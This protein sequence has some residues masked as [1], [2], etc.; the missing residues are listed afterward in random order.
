MLRQGIGRC[1]QPF[2]YVAVLED[3]AVE[4]L[5][6]LFPGKD[7]RRQAEIFYRVA[8]FH[9]RYFVI[10]DIVLVG[11]NDLPYQPLPLGPEAVP[12]AEC[13]DGQ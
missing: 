7:L 5:L 1:L 10:E 4:V 11:H 3:H 12:A 2:G 6:C 13:A 9:P 8:P